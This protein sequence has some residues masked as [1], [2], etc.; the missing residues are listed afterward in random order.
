MKKHVKHILDL[1]SSGCGAILFILAISL[2]LGFIGGCVLADHVN[3]EGT[4]ALEK[5]LDGYVALI[6]SGEISTPGFINLFWDLFRWPLFIFFLGITPLG[7]L[8]IPIV[9]LIRGFLLSFTVASL[10][11]VL[12]YFGLGFS[13]VTFG[14]TGFIYIPAL[15]FFGVNCFFASGLIAERLTNE[16]T[17]SNVLGYSF[18]FRCILCVFVFVLCLLIKH[19][20]IP[21]LLGLIIDAFA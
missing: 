13:F 15:L 7:F 8:G 5:Y 2:F 4:M 18:L 6:Y 3:G 20:I 21:E 1:P 10:F 9:L 16:G 14:I 12:G 19:Q 17:K 11:R